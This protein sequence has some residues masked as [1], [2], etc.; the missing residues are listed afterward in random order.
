MELEWS[1]LGSYFKKP[2]RF[3]QFWIGHPHFKEKVGKWWDDLIKG[4]DQSMD[5]FQEKIKGL[6]EKIKK[7]NKEEFGNIFTHKKFLES[8]LKEIHKQGMNEGYMTK[9]LK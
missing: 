9:L 3:E 5:K 7:Q 1:E 6:K 4:E 8:R 2:F